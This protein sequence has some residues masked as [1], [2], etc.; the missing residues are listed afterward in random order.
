MGSDADGPTGG[1]FT[2]TFDFTT[3]SPPGS[4]NF[5]RLRSM[6]PADIQAG[7]EGGD[8]FTSATLKSATLELDASLSLSITSLGRSEQEQQT[9]GIG[10]HELG[11]ADAAA[12]DPLRF[13]GLASPVNQMEKGKRQPHDKRQVER[14]AN[15]YRDEALRDFPK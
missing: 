3:D 8:L 11:H 6:S 2:P 13:R 10:L 9:I 7:I 1:L 5:E 4:G 14:E 12:R 15:Q